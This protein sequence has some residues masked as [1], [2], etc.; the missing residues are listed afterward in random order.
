VFQHAFT[1]SA[2]IAVAGSLAAAGVAVFMSRAARRAAG[3]SP[4]TALRDR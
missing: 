2:M 3:L 4:V 1:E